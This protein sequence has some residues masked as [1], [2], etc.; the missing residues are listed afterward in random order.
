MYIAHELGYGPTAI[1]KH[2]G[3]GHATVIYSKKTIQNLLD[4]EDQLVTNLYHNIIYE[5]KKRY[6][7]DGDVQSNSSS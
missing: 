7:D 5:Y 1:S 4:C 3:F 2:I 6:S